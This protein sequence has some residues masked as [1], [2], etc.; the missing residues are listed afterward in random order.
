MKKKEMEEILDGIE[1]EGFDYY[2]INYTSPNENTD[3]E[4]AKLW[5]EYK[6]AHNNLEDFIKEKAEKLG[7][8]Y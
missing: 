3:K 6:Q 2:F 5:N 8:E 4:L 1:S 7:L